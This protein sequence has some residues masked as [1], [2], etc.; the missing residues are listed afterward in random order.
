MMV[1]NFITKRILVNNGS[2]TCILFWDAFTQMGID[3][4]CLWLAPMP[5]NG[6]S[7][8]MIQLVG[9]IT[10]SVLVGKALYTTSTMADFTVV[11]ARSLYN[12]ILG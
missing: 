5:L 7:R 12:T 10:L 3:P 2:S 8:D 4:A 9:T 1:T 11:K 6:F